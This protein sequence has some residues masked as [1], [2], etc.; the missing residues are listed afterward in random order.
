MSG[1]EVKRIAIKCIAE[2]PACDVWALAKA[3]SEAYAKEGKDVD[4]NR[5]ILELTEFGSGAG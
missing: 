5:L 3:V 2:N 1:D 4:V